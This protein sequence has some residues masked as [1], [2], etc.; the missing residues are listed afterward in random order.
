MTPRPRTVW[1]GQQS[2]ILDIQTSPARASAHLGPFSHYSPT[3]PTPWT[4]WTETPQIRT[5]SSRI[6]FPAMILAWGSLDCIIIQI[7]YK[8][9]QTQG[10][11]LCPPPPL[12]FFPKLRIQIL[13]PK[14]N[15]LTCYNKVFKKK[16]LRVL[17][18]FGPTSSAKSEISFDL[19]I[20]FEL[21]TC[22]SKTK[23]GLF[24]SSDLRS[25]RD[26]ML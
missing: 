25:R 4:V 14:E 24:L 17:W 8:Y 22:C 18:L 5:P 13:P 21:N 15:Y 16:T 11:I 3:S 1:C 12:L 20:A 6:K 2:T 19:Q 23:F 9:L 10:I 26:Q 7:L